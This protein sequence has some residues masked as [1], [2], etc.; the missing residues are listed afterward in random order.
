MAMAP[1]CM[2]TAISTG[3]SGLMERRK[4]EDCRSIKMEAS[5]TKV[6]GRTIRSMDMEN[7]QSHQEPITRGSSRKVKKMVR[8]NTTMLLRKN[9]F[10]RSTK[11][12]F[13]RSTRKLRPRGAEKRSFLPWLSIK[14]GLTLRTLPPSKCE[15][16]K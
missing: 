8:V 14:R 6:S 1:C 10:T 4:A 16:P 15:T 13:K 9:C 11:V 2:Q 5:S 7:C 3:E 12:E